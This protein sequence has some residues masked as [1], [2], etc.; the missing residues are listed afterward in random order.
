M[1]EGCDG[2]KRAYMSR[3]SSIEVEEGSEGEK[4]GVGGGPDKQ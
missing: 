3:G 1:S 4:A 2:R